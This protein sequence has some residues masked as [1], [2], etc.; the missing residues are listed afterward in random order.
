M[1]NKN[2][3]KAE[4]ISAGKTYGDV[5]NHLGINETTLYRKIARD[6]DFSRSE[7]QKI[8][9]LL[10]IDNPAPIFFGQTLA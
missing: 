10:C 8:C 1:F 7:I 9:D 2:K 4:V 5:A 3:F 6:G